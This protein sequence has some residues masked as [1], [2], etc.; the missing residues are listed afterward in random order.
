MP[1]EPVAAAP[2]RLTWNA[3]GWFGSQI[4]STCWIAICAALLIRHDYTIA[5]VV[6]FLFL[7]ANIF[8][9]VLWLTR[10]RISAYLGLNALLIMIGTVSL[11]AVFVIDRSGLWHV[12]EGVGGQVSTRHM[13]WL[14]VV[15]ITALLALF[16]SLNRSQTGSDTNN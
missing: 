15:M 12:V 14:I 10:N 1:S 2:K 5:T 4:G 16:W 7:A 8:G 11:A 6:L 13:Y 3:G 9:T